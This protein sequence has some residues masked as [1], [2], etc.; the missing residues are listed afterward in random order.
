MPLPL[1]V[2]SPPANLPLSVSRFGSRGEGVAE[3][4]GGRVYVSFAV[5]GDQI[6][7]EVEGDRGRISA[8]LQPGDARVEP[9]CPYFGSCGGCATQML[10][11]PSYA[12]WK[13]GLVVEA[14]RRAGVAADV[15]PLVDGH[16]EGRRRAAFH[17]R[18]Q[19]GVAVVGFMKARAHDI[20]AVDACPV[21]APEM[22]ATLPAARAIANALSRV[23]K[24]LD[25]FVTA[26]ES[27]L[28]VDVR[29]TGPLGASARQRLIAAAQALGLARLSNHGE[30]LIEREAPILTMGRARLSPPPGA[31]L[32]ATLAGERALV[33]AVRKG[34]GSAHRVADLFAGVGTFALRLA[35]TAHVQAVETDAPA[36]A[37]LSKASRNAEGLRQ[38]VTETRDLFRRP[39][40]GP[41]LDSFEAVVF[42]PPRAG[43]ETQAAALAQ[44]SV[45][46]VIA[47]S[48][49][50]GSFARDAA[51]L[52]AGGYRLETVTP[53]DQFRHS[54]H[55]EI[56][57]VFTKQ[58]RK[59]R[60]GR[61]LG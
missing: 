27:G 54:A 50:P 7:A 22:A 37:A 4:E 5:P 44:S 45:P 47:A 48:C 20:V 56:V 33:D 19:E 31:F 49:A 18:Y 41:E 39:L 15:D 58:P 10:A 59:R 52:V 40:A 21:L 42:D 34:A 17:A 14:L 35:E 30:T 23:R 61:L 51:T 25:L 43:A 1:S 26:T 57:A 24:P 9:F 16:G 28:D 13:R 55:V 46:R 29:G 38:V 3:T 60:T 36:L 6:L 2:I 32:Q 12:Q 8:I 11:Q 53:I